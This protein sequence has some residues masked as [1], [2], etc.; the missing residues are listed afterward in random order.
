LEAI[1]RDRIL[2]SWFLGGG[3]PERIAD[4][5]DSLRGLAS[6]DVRAH[7]FPDADDACAEVEVCGVFLFPLDPVEPF[8]WGSGAGRSLGEALRGAEAEALLRLGFLRGE[9]VPDAPP[10]L[11]PT[12]DFHLD[13]FLHP[14]H[15]ARI[16]HWLT[17]GMPP[18]HGGP[19]PRPPSEEPLFAD[20]TPPALSGRAVV[21]RAF[22]PDRMP[23]VFG[24]GHPW[25]PRPA[26]RALVHPIA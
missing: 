19:A 8:C 1:E 10:P 21:V 25:V 15:Q 7:R 20:L 4:V 9:A 11:S 6:H 23:L 16:R 24:E 2:R 3:P 26:D 14:P 22:D 18:A 5:P 12:P 17:R 13:F